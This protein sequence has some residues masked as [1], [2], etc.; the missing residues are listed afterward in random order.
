VLFRSE[1]AKRLRQALALAV[2][3]LRLVDPLWTGLDECEGALLIKG[4]AN[5]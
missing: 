3:E 1:Q 2:E 5:A 4:N